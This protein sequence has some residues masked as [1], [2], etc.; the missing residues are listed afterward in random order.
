MRLNQ[1]EKEMFNNM[2]SYL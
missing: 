1:S 2:Y